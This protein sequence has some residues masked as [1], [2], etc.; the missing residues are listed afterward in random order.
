MSNTKLT[1]ATVEIA[2]IK[3]NPYTLWDTEVRG[4][5]LRVFPSG[6]MSWIAK[7]RV[8]GGRD[9][10]VRSP[11]IA[12]ANL[13]TAKDARAAARTEIA[14]ARLGKDPRG[15]R[16]AKRQEMTVADLIDL[17]EREG[18]VV[19]RGM[20]IGKPM[21]PMTKQYTM[22]RLRNHIVPLIGK[23]RASEITAG[24]VESVYRSVT[25][26]KTAKD[27]KLGKR[28]R[29]IVTGGDGA[30][31][32]VVRDLSAV[33]SFALRQEIVKN[34]PVATASV[35]KTDNRRER[36]LSTDEVRSLGKALIDLE[37]EGA[38]PKAINIIRLW[39]LTG[40]R[41]N[42]IASLKWAEVDFAN[43]RLVLEET[44]TGR[45]IRPLGDPAIAILAELRAQADSEAVF[46]FPA[47][48]GKSHYQNTRK[49]LVQAVSKARL[50]DV[51]PHIL[52]HTMGN[53]ITSAGESLLMV[54]AVLGHSN[55]HSS[56]LYAHVAHDPSR[57]VANRVAAGAA[58]ALGVLPPEE[59]TKA[60]A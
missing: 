23:R 6:K 41:R 32:K 38:N 3:S 37:G 60:A 52:R 51:S 19:Q 31:R 22:A 11:T 10:P 21:K 5:G 15:E 39:V 54:G 53:M 12:D 43:K 42:E 7:Y 40:C 26:G 50:V 46:V 45:S 55:A 59:E 9:G 8:G 16:R 2:E 56:A 28:V 29:I 44:K 25:K 47:E 18:C 24:D 27:E 20:N 49:V 48:T 1:S 4:F 30:A 57:I 36:Y 17:Y 14:A 34:N 58:T 13:M 33:F 35:R